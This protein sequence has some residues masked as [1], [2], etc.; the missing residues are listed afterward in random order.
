MRLVDTHAH[1]DDV[2]DPLSVL[3]TAEGRGVVAVV[4]VGSDTESNRKTL[5]ITDMYPDRVF[6]ALGF[7]PWELI[8]GDAVVGSALDFIEENISR[9]VAVGEVGLD[10]KKELVRKAGKELQHTVLESLLIIARRHDK[11]VMVHSRYA[12]GDVLDLVQRSGVRQAVFH[13][14]TGPT[15]VLRGVVESGYYLSATPACAY[16]Q[17]HRRAIKETPLDRLL[18]ETDSPVYYRS[19]DRAAEPV[20]VAGVLVEVAVI[21][22]LP[23]EQVAE[24][25]T[26]NAVGLFKLKLGG[27]R[28]R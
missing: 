19:L 12:W 3:K 11:P 27:G 7:H 22:G 25:T 14:F 28:W 5:D 26:D 21:K 20:D 2:S 8:R 24:A 13:W 10:Y 6:P 16:H 4:A 9:A 17:E 23:P 15:S 18:L 1:L